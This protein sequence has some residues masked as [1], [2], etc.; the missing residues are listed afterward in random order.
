MIAASVMNRLILAFTAV[1]GSPSSS[2]TLASYLVIHTCIRAAKVTVGLP[3]GL[4]FFPN[5]PSKAG[6]GGGRFSCKALMLL[7]LPGTALNPFAL[8]KGVAPVFIYLL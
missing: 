5:P 7:C 4:R 3:T 1:S 2:S 8:E 6:G